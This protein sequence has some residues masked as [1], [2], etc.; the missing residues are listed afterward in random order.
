M[1]GFQINIKHVGQDEFEL[2]H[3][4]EVQLNRP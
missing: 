3:V 4:A 1:V 2:E